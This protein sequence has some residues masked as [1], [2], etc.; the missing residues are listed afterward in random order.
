ME[1]IR[2]GRWTIEVDREATRRVQLSRGSGQPE[3]CDCQDDQN[4]VAAR[5]VAN[6]EAARILLDKL[7]LPYDRES[8]IGLPMELRPNVFIYNGFFHFIGRIIE[9][10]AEWQSRTPG[11]EVHL[12]T[13]EGDFAVAFM[14]P[15]G[16]IPPEFPKDVPLVHLEFSTIVPWLLDEPYTGPLLLNPPK[17]SGLRARIHQIGSFIRSLFLSRK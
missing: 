7:G 8:E 3:T 9:A 4:F 1:T 11:R 12:D 14:E 15:H 17:I 6:P 2:V 13:I 5:N 16:L 10:P